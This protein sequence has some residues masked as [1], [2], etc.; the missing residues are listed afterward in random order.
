MVDIKDFFKSSAKS[1]ITKRK[2]QTEP[3]VIDDDDEVVVKIPPAKKQKTSIKIKDDE[4]DDFNDDDDDMLIE[5]GS[6]KANESQTPI[7]TPEKI[8]IPPSSPI[9]P[10]TVTPKKVSAPKKTATPKKSV[11]DDDDDVHTLLGK[12]PD[13]ELPESTES[14]TFNY[15]A[16]KA[17]QESQ[18]VSASNDIVIPEGKPNCL[19]GLTI[20]FTGVFPHLSRDA[21]E[22]LAKQYG[23]K[24]TKSISSK[25]SIVVLGDDAG[26]SK[27]KKIK[28]F[29][30]KAINEEGFLTL[31]SGMPA[32][33]G[34]NE[35]AIREKLKR[36]KQEQDAINKAVRLQE[37]QELQEKKDQ[38]NRAKSNINTNEKIISDSD[39]LWTVKYAPTKIEQICG[40]KTTV[41]KLKTWLETWQDKFGNKPP[42]KGDTEFR[43]VLI[44]GP[45]GIGKTTAAHL[46]AKD[47]GFEIIEKNASD[48]RSKKLLSTTIKNILDNTSITGFYKNNQKQT[49]F[50]IIMDEVDG[51]SGG[52]RGG[53][54]ELASYCRKTQTP[55]ILICNDKS[56][57]KMRPFDRVTLD[58]PFRRPSAREMKS[59]LMTI[60]LREKI[61]LDPNIIDQLVS[62]T[63][64]DI[65][66]IINLLSTVSKTSSS[67]DSKNSTQ[68]AKEW[69]K[70]STLKIFDIIPS[71]FSSRSHSIH[72]P[73]F[74][75]F[76][77]YF[78][79]HAFVPPMIQEN[80]LNT[81][82]NPSNPLTLKYAGKNHLEAVSN[83]ADSISFADLVD[84]KIHSSEQTWSLMPFHAL[85]ST[86][87]PSSYV[88]GGL[89]GR[90][91]FAS[92]F[93]QNSKMGKYYRILREIEYR[94]RLRTGGSGDYDLRLFY[95]PLLIEKLLAPLLEG[96]SED[97]AITEIIS[98]LDYYYL[99]KVDWD[100]LMEFS[101]GDKK[102]VDKVKKI[103]T[104]VKSKFT[105]TYNK[106]DHPA[107]I[108]K[109]AVTT[110]IAGKAKKDKIDLDDAIEED[111]EPEEEDDE[112]EP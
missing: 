11:V 34:D 86:I 77:Y 73:L 98:T 22:Q 3:I 103:P 4:D 6:S 96:S 82:P 51:M 45:P 35:T 90:V 62:A 36:E 44:H 33:G 81:Q 19:T 83:A 21:A 53:V 95:V 47:L 70:N 31:I 92:W 54:G 76:E 8:A 106:G 102:A 87:I 109:P 105:R 88:A 29:K 39:R 97:E 24:V 17:K 85:V 110:G 60:A 68:I 55:L 69:Q 104:K 65:R 75:L 111:E 23:A 20:V 94:M 18:P 28:Q 25:T 48:V 107:A 108:I 12:I 84:A 63:S 9:K 38:A 40:N 14:G 56:L 27:V 10:K 5:L 71:L 100:L 52:D 93:G 78:D 89:R 26:P 49:K 42:Q 67:I 59:R 1:A 57:P 101:V 30:I 41:L 50:V 13:A 74:K 72:T 64:N 80:Y 91:N 66:Q 46:V 37:E 2:K 112:E 15:H 61:K 7:K 58:L 79:D 32:D 99:T 43:A 16:Y